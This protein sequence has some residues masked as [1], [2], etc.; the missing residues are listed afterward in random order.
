MKRQK[1][2]LI[3]N[4]KLQAL[5]EEGWF[6]KQVIERRHGGLSCEPDYYYVLLEKDD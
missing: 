2:E 5:N 3:T 6:V 4:E 1:I